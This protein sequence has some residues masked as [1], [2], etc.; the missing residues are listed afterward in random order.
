MALLGRFLAPWC[1][2]NSS[3]RLN[4]LPVSSPLAFRYPRSCIGIEKSF[5]SKVQMEKEL[6]SLK[7]QVDV[8]TAERDSALAA[9]LLN[10]K[11]KSLTQQLRFFE[12]ERLSALARMSEVEENTKV[13]VAELESCRATLLKEKRGAE[14]LTKSL[15]EKQTTLDGAEAAAAHWRDE[16]KS[17]AEETRD[18]VQET[19]E[20]LMDQVCHLHPVIDFSMISLDTRWDPKAKRIYNPKAEAQEQSEPVAEEQPGPEAGVPVGGTP[21]RLFRRLR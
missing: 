20:I 19:F 11:I 9:P 7:D 21:R 14:G 16:W 4:I 6:A 10:A 18:M 17:L 13:Q 2:S 15:R 3:E 1:R 12:G 5:A 8:L